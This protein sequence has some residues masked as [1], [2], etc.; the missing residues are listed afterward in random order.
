MLRRRK[1]YACVELLGFFFFF[2]I[3]L[4]F[5]CAVEL[6]DAVPTALTAEKD[7]SLFLGTSTGSVSLFD[8]RK[9]D[10]PTESFVLL[11]LFF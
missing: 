9:V 2:L 10:S 1:V 11:F 4:V 8:L 6:V 3:I 7:T 5:P